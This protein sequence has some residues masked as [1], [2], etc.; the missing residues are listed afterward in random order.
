M[1]AFNPSGYLKN[2]LVLLLVGALLGLALSSYLMFQA[3]EHQWIDMHVRKSGFAGVMYFLLIGAL[4]SPLC[5]SM[6]CDLTLWFA[7]MVIR[8]FVRQIY[9][10][11]ITN[12]NRFLS[13]RPIVKNG[14][15]WS[16]IIS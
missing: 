4:L 15:C 16:V 2:G 3:F 13:H 7:R 14:Y 12:V 10:Q 8:P 11:R 9:S 5:V 6:S 1:I